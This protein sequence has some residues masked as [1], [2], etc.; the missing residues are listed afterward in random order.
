[1]E[2]RI[3]NKHLIELSGEDYYVG[4]SLISNLSVGKEMEASLNTFVNTRG[5]IIDGFIGDR[6]SFQTSF[7]ENQAVFPNYIDSLIRTQD[8]VIPGQGRGRTIMIMDL[9]MLVHLALFLLKHQIILLFNLVMV[10]ILL[11]MVID[12]YYFQIILLIILFY[13]SIKFWKFQYTN[14]YCEFQV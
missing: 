1:M 11:E 8:F 9:I 4:G 6:V 3:F 2:S 10:N 13:V 14:L 7:L 12:L 5:F